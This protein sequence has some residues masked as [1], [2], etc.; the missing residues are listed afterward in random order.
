MSPR[1]P[2]VNDSESSDKS[3]QTPNPSQARRCDDPMETPEPEEELL[4]LTLGRKKQAQS[5]LYVRQSSASV[6]RPN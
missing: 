6:N 1:F 3:L 5:I 4:W 2:N